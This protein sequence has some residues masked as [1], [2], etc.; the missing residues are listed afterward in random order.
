MKRSFLIF[1]I[2][3]LVLAGLASC[4]KEFTPSW[5]EINDLSD[6]AN[7]KY[8]NYTV[9]SAR[10]YILVENNFVSGTAS[11]YTNVYPS[12]ATSYMSIPAFYKSF[13]IRDTLP[14]TTQPALSFTATLDKGAF[15]T[16]FTYDSINAP[17]FKLVKDAIVV[18][19]DT[20]A[21]V[22]FAN[23]A[24]ST[25]A[26]P[27]IDIFS[28][29][30]GANVAT[31]LAPTDVTNFVPYASGILDTLHIRETGRTVNLV[32]VNGFSA[33]T[34]RSYTVV[35]RGSWRLAAGTTLGRGVSSFLSY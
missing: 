14:T 35:F 2:A 23:F 20:T 17:K 9:N 26:M 32:S 28:T 7:I 29:R 24:Y 3:M 6:R 16:L 15:Y 12:G 19:T 1:N 25:A 21:R 27:N 8:A 5:T 34:K 18:P 30:L 22:R 4:K 33:I 10:N 31:N 13:T 11:A